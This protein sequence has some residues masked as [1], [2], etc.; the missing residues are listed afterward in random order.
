MNCG[1]NTSKLAVEVLE[2]LQAVVGKENVSVCD[3]NCCSD[4]KTK[5]I[6]CVAPKSAQEVAKIISIANKNEFRVVS[7]NNPEW[8]VDGTKYP[9]GGILVDLSRIDEVV[10]FDRIAMSVKVGAGCTWKALIDICA[11][12]GFILG[13]YP[14]DTS[15]TVGSWVVANGMGIGSYKNGSAKSNVLN[16]QVVA[17]DATTLE[18]GYDKIGYY[19]SGYNL[20]QL[21]S[22][23]EGTLGIITMATLKVLPA[24]VTKAIAYE[25][26]EFKDISK[27]L[28]KLVHHASIKPYDISYSSVSKALLVVLQGAEEFITLEEQEIDAIIGDSAKKIDGAPIW[29]ERCGS[30]N[31]GVEVIVPVK[32]WEAFVID[33]GD[34]VVFGSIA[35]RSTALFITLG[36][37]ANTLGE[38][39]A[40][41]GGRAVSSVSFEWTPS[42]LDVHEDSDLS[43][44]VTPE[45]ISKLEDIV[46]KN[47][48]TTNGVDLILYSKDMAP[49]PKM[50]G[51]AFNNMPD[52]V[53]RPS[54]VKE[55]S[56][57]AALAYKHG[58][59]MVPRGNSSWGLGGCMPTSGGIVIDM[60]S[61]MNGIIDMDPIGM[62]VKAGAGITWKELLE[63]CMKKGFII[64]SYPSSF[65]SATI[66]AWLSTNGMGVGSYKYG[67][68]KDNVLN[69]EVVLCDGTVLKTGY[70]NIGA[71]KSGYNLNQIFSGSE[72]TLC[73]FGTVTFRMYPMGT[74]KPLA[75]EYEAFRDMNAAIQA[76]VN[77][78]SVKPL[79]I[80]FADHNHYE[81]QRKAGCHTPDVKNLLMLTI[82]GDDKFNALEEQTLDAIVSKNGGKKV[83]DD[84]AAHEWEER[85]YEFRARKVGVGEIPAEVVVPTHEWGAFSDVCYDGFKKMKMEVGGIIGNVIDRNTAL[86]MP[87]YFKDDESLLGMTAFAFNFYLG[88]RATEFGGRTT[89]FGVFFAWNL[90]NIHNA[91]TVAY[92]RAL[93]TK[94]DPHDVVNPGHV[95]CGSTR[96]G[97]NMGKQLMGLGSSVMQ[98]AKKMLPVNTTFA[99]N[100]ARFRYNILEERKAEDRVH[101]LGK[102]TQ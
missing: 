84:I 36:E 45:I 10:N 62:Y 91:D 11:K 50:A 94:L 75:Y 57:I 63:A 80:S 51:I 5:A 74:I 67:A 89:G 76:I 12:E 27:P 60:S 22:G 65:P 90:D 14:T 70:D 43:R 53:V 40:K 69:M 72:G 16:L 95:V 78:P 61:K 102:G 85:C 23:S 28:Q 35:D 32:D 19:M 100:R 93:K 37:T 49:L 55:I 92:M 21:F 68:A 52:V 18:T 47:N 81:N 83:S 15:T 99:D 54:K 38:K 3:S 87:Y 42:S 2:A 96:F 25:F 86:Y 1:E 48:V 58:I 59:P 6:V 64:G 33:L 26:P 97:I 34:D 73:V 41:Y 44:A 71:Y 39:A 88:D 8:A 56:E 9:Q 24:G 7:S 13:S 79:H 98:L 101:E 20:T 46:G 66:G 29:E 30:K 17:A 31:D 4:K 82:Q 77:N